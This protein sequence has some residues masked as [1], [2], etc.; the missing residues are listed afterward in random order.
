MIPAQGVTA[1]TVL[2]IL[3]LT[4]PQ[5]KIRVPRSLSS[6]PG[7]AEPGAIRRPWYAMIQVFP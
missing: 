4:D 1:F 7:G 3:L 2:A 6:W 5:V